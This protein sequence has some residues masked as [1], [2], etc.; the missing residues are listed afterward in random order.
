MSNF[1]ERNRERLQGDAS[2]R[3]TTTSSSS[4]LLGRT[5]LQNAA[6]ID[7]DRIE[8]DPQHR[9]T[10]DETSL[11][12]LARSIEQ[13][14]QLQ[15]IRVR[16][17]EA[18]QKYVIIAGERRYRA[19]CLAELSSIDCVIAEGELT[20]GD[21]LREQIIEN[22]LREDLK[23]TEQATAFKALMDSEG[24]D[25][26]T[27]AA[28]IHVSP[29][30][31]SRSLK[32]L[33]LSAKELQAVDAGKVAPTVAIQR[34]QKETATAKPKSQKRSKGSKERKFVT[35]VGTLTLKARRNLTDEVWLQSL[36]EAIAACKKPG[37]SN[38]AA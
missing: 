7:V 9:E 35:A 20:E 26:K 37:L 31:V 36:Q 34:L 28:Q 8:V 38:K 13:H 24:W 4:E 21:I 27:L 6:K 14:G 23:P 2:R 19:V 32:L 18:R 1:F 30:T 33:Q 29:M 25:G 11:Q 3:T 15:P 5:R 22:A 12:E 17:D 10:F 16:W